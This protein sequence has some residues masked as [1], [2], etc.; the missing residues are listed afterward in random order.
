[1][2]GMDPVLGFVTRT[3]ADI[4]EQF[5]AD[6][7]AEISPSLDTSSTSPIGQVN[8][9]IAKVAGELWDLAQATYVAGDPDRNTGDGQDA[10]AA[11]TGTTRLEATHSQ[12]P[13]ELELDAGTTVPLGSLMA[14]LGNPSSQWELLGEEPPFGEPVILGDVV[15]VADGT[16]TA[17]FQAVETGPIPANATT[18]TQIITPVSGWNSG[19]NP[20]DADPGRD[21]EVSS[22]MRTRRE[23]E[24]AAPGSTP[25]DALRAEL[26]K[27]LAFWG[28]TS[29]F[30][31]VVENVLDVTDADGRPPHS[32]EALIDD[33]PTPVDD[34]EIAQVIWDGKAGGI[35]TFGSTNGDATDALGNL[36]SMNFNRPDLL[37][38]Y[39]AVSIVIEDAIFPDDGDVQ[40]KAAM[41]A[42]GDLYKPGQDVIRNSFFGPIFSIPGVTNV[43]VL[44]LDFSPG[45]TTDTDLVVAVRE[46]AT[47]DTSNIAVSHV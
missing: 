38:V 19:S 26:Y 44:D 32:I 42:F 37:P 30:V 31:D 15:A 10:V 45:P 27:L 8:G 47:F 33:D 20:Q 43:T 41:A 18:I 24:L 16:Y 21:I 12:V 7:V 13:I 23:Q 2:P 6:E 25:V 22:A 29:G 3:T 35:R 4:V 46:R 39:F 5:A 36:R 9:A 17:R 34:D 14:V 40:I 11:I 1:M 28:V